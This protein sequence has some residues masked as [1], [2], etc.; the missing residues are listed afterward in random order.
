MVNA[1]GTLILL[2]TIGSS[3]IALRLDALSRLNRRNVT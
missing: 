2:L 1:I 3:L